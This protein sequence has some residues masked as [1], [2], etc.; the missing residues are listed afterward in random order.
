MGVEL[1]GM[2][3]VR[4]RHASE[5]AGR[6]NDGRASRSAARSWPPLSPEA[7]TTP[8]PWAASVVLVGGPWIRI[9]LRCLTTTRGHK[10]PRRP[11]EGHWSRRWGAKLPW[12]VEVGDDEPGREGRGVA[13]SRRGLNW[14]LDRE[15]FAVCGCNLNSSFI[16]I[17]APFWFLFVLAKRPT[18]TGELER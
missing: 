2:G 10:P 1:E 18:E 9:H 16:L 17:V 15:G 8:W 7:P 5:I 14:D 6:S 4:P 13:G 11:R 3:D 12:L